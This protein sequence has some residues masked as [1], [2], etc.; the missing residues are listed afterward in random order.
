MGFMKPVFF[1]LIGAVVVARRRVLAWKVV[2]PQG[3]SSPAPG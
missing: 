1:D 2:L 3:R